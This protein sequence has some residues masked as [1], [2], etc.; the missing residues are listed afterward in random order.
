MLV[1]CEAKQVRGF[2]QLAKKKLPTGTIKHKTSKRSD[3]ALKSQSS[4]GGGCMKMSLDN[5]DTDSEP[6]I[7]FRPVLPGLNI[8]VYRSSAP[9]G[10]AMK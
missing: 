9:E 2:P 10:A 8:N 4:L 1:S 7:N 3:E 6:V 5:M